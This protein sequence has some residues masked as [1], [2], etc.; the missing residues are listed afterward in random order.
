MDKDVWKPRTEQDSSSDDPQPD[1]L[2]QGG[3]K[4]SFI[5]YLTFLNN[6]KLNKNFL[7]GDLDDSDSPL[8]SNYKTLCEGGFKRRRSKT[9]AQ[10]SK[11]PKIGPTFQLSRGTI[12]IKKYF[13]KIS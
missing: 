3:T 10:L 1:C 13:M 12:N 8:R 9:N 6:E 2:E 4:Q 5:Q 7:D 11:R